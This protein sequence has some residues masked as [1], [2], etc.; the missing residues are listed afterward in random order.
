MF[1]DDNSIV[2]KVYEVDFIGLE[3]G[4]VIVFVIGF[5]GEVDGLIVFGVW[6]VF[7]DGIIFLFGELISI[8]EVDVV[9]DEFLIVLNFVCI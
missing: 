4:V 6:V 9:F 7:L 2:V 1:V 5:L 3:G 8:W